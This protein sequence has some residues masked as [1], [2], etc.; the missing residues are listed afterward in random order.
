MSF[1]ST[2][3]RFSSDVSDPMSS[4]I[5]QHR[6][7]DALMDDLIEQMFRVLEHCCPSNASAALHLLQIEF[8]GTDCTKRRDAYEAYARQFR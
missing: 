8:P 6:L 2:E 1:P 3:R 7:P 5:G 4:Q